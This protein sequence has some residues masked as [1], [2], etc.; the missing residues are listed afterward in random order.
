MGYHAFSR[1]VAGLAVGLVVIGALSASPVTAQTERVPVVVVVPMPPLV[2][3]PP[4]GEGRFGPTLQIG[5]ASVDVDIDHSSQP[6]QVW[7]R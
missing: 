6:G 4:S 3:L 7:V 2:G 5:R 1:G